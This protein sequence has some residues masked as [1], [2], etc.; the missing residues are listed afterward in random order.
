MALGILE[1]HMQKY[2]MGHFFTSFTMDSELM[3][4]L[5]ELG[6][7]Q[8][9]QEN[10]GSSFSTSAITTPRRVSRGK[11]KKRKMKYGDFLK[12]RAF[13]QQRNHSV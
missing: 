5:N 11:R 4:D 10:T 8:N 9:P 1:T 13:S 12:G 2:E 6:N 7:H 3:K